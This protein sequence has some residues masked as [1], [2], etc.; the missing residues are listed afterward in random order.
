MIARAANA[1]PENGWYG[2]EYRNGLLLIC[3]FLQVAPRAS[4][5]NLELLEP[6]SSFFFF[7]IGVGACGVDMLTSSKDL[8]M[9]SKDTVAVAARSQNSTV[10]QQKKLVEEEFIQN[11]ASTLRP[12]TASVTAAATA[13]EQTTATSGMQAQNSALGDT[14]AFWTSHRRFSGTCRYSIPR[15]SQA[16]F[17]RR[18]H[19]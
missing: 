7:L 4:A 13:S 10:N 6:A 15:A 1:G 5:A 3:I 19:S 18:R 12:Y 16:T 14:A 17:Q 8:K 9:R 2:C 11:P